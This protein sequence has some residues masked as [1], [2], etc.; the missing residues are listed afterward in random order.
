MPSAV[1]VLVQ[2]TGP[3]VTSRP[4]KLFAAVLEVGAFLALAVVTVI[5]RRTQPEKGRLEAIT[6]GPALVVDAEVALHDPGRP[7]I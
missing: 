6:L 5:L 1:G 4:R 3:A 2:F 7:T